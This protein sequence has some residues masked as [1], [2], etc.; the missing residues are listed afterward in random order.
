ME[1]CM[2]LQVHIATR[3]VVSGTLDGE[4][5]SAH[6]PDTDDI[7]SAKGAMRPPMA[8][9]Q[10]TRRSRPQSWSPYPRTPAGPAPGICRGW[11]GRSVRCT[12]GLPGESSAP[13]RADTRRIRCSMPSPAPAAGSPPPCLTRKL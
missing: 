1:A 12:A 11:Q 6:K 4:L 9:V 8:L 10:A 3:E 7:K 5:P 2:K 13:R